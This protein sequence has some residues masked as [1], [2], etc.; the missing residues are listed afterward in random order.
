MSLAGCEHHNRLANAC[1]AL[2]GIPLWRNRI[3]GACTV[4][5]L[6]RCDRALDARPTV[7]GYTVRAR[8][9]CLLA[10]F[11]KAQSDL[12]AA[13]QLK[14]ATS[15]VKLLH[16]MLYQAQGQWCKAIKLLSTY[17]AELEESLEASYIARANRGACYRMLRD[18]D[19]AA[20]DL[21]SALS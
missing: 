2:T 10:G 21:E 13:R 7:H 15:Q 16:A 3:S 9:H 6:C 1:P 19:A 4:V 18:Y 11:G 5:K 14:G 20:E 17:I 8:C 12:M